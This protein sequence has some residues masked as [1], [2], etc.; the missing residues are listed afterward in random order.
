LRQVSSETRAGFS[1]LRAFGLR[2]FLALTAVQAVIVGVLVAMAEFRKRRGERSEGFP[3]E[4]QPEIELESGEDRLK[5]Y[6][7]GVR[8][9]ED[10]IQEIERAEREIF[11][12]TFIWKGDEVGRRFVDALARKAR[13]GVSVYVVFDGLANAFVPPSFKRFPKEI[14]TLH[15][16]PLSG[17][18]KILN[19]RNV[20][21]F[22]RHVMSVDGKT[23][24]L[25][26]YNI[27]SLYAAGWRDTHVRV[28]GNAV[29]EVDN[30]FAD[31]WNSHRTDE[32]P[33]VDPTRDRDWNP[34]VRVRRNDP[35][36]RIFPI[37][38]MYLE[39]IDRANSH[40][41]LT[42]AYFV[43]DRALKA[44]LMDAAKR[45]V[46]VQ[47]LVPEQ[48]NHVTADWL[49]RRHFHELLE[50]G[51][52]IFRYKHIMI[53]SKTAT[54][55]GLWSTIGSAN[56]DR[57]SML[58]NYELNIEVY[59]KRLAAQMERMFEVDKTNAE[60]LTLEEWEN[61]PLPAKVVEQALASLS[62]L[63]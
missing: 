36:M 14:H 20:F 53:H 11:I 26:G 50:A 42:N 2:V 46:D 5:I 47:V 44:H 19:P 55:D 10:M 33:K 18:K 37:R 43:P 21:R 22:H 13:E 15:F 62:P 29:R 59:S 45:G 49:A 51:V 6:A 48:S 17:P 27:G 56:I 35:F 41:Y 23:A 30:A 58:G 25:G 9:Y 60:E 61:R 40:V 12:G 63:V 32:L 7:F 34:A 1:A 16:R 31:F 57:Y 3:W 38:G 54:V 52:R 24:F 8:L 39:A 4:D 28:R